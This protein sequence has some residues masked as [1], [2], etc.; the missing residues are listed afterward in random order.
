MPSTDRKLELQANDIDVST[1]SQTTAYWADLASPVA[2]ETTECSNGL[3][4]TDQ[5]FKHSNVSTRKQ[6]VIFNEINMA[7]VM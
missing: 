3:I 5:Y 1:V 4:Y 2:S 7:A 6:L